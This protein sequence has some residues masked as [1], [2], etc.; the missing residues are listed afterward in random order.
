MNQ[1]RVLHVGAGNMYGGIES[2]L[3]ESA[4][5]RDFCPEL[6]QEF[7]LCFEGRLSEELCGVGARVHMLGAMK[8]S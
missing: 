3:L 1:L 5:A 7:A 6:K 2:H 8:A 4:R